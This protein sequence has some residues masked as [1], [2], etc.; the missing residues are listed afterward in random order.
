MNL[1]KRERYALG[2]LAA[3]VLY[4]AVPFAQSVEGIQLGPA[5]VKIFIFS[6]LAL[7]LNVVVGYAGLLQLGIAAF[8]ALGAYITGILTVSDYPFQTGFWIALPAAVIGAGAAGL[9]LGAPTLRLRG[10]YLAIVTLGFA[11]VIKYALINL[12]EITRGARTL[13]P[14][15][16][17]SLSWL[18]IEPAWESN[19]RWYYYMILVILVLMVI[20][21]QNLERSRLGRALLAIRE[22][23]LAAS[24]MGI[25]PTRVKLIAFSLG[26][27]IA[28]LAGCLYAT[29]LQ[30][31]ASPQNYDF[32]VSIIV[33]CFLIVGG[34]GNIYGA[35]LGTFV[36]LGFDSILSPILDKQ[37]Q[38]IFAGSQSVFLSF[39]NWRWFI[40]GLALVLM[41]R[42]RPEGALPARPEE[43]GE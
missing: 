39:S 15:P 14:V 26:A 7:G 1:G 18:R 23:E 4:P 6:L 33:L 38:K 17:P 8:F 34:I 31:T 2:A 13:G 30:N 25:N 27:A 24:C 12:D 10:D 21:L 41:M 20:F 36:I 35:I 43:R 29:S 37:V 9:V 42:F 5:F 19:Y 32:A 40:F 28:G 11:E 3:L 22:D 16:P